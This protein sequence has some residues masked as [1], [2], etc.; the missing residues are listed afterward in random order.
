MVSFNHRY[1]CLCTSSK[2]AVIL[3]YLV[4]SMNGSVIDVFTIIKTVNAANANSKLNVMKT[5][6]N[7]HAHINNKQHQQQKT[8]VFIAT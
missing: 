7:R 1:R 8:H 5:Y 4:L 2:Y 6:T 3:F